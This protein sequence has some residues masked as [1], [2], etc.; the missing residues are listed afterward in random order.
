MLMDKLISSSYIAI[1]WAAV[2]ETV[3]D[4][5]DGDIIMITRLL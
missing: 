1:Q 4:G 5:G 3:Y 2:K